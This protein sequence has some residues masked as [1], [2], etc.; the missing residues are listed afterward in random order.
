MDR[1]QAI[2]IVLQSS[3]YNSKYDQTNCL[4]YRFY[5][6]GRARNATEK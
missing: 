2:Q 1:Q 4:R 5:D 3:A 6:A